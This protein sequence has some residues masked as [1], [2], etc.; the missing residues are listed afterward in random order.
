M[1]RLQHLRDRLSLA[2]VAIASLSVLL[3]GGMAWQSA[4]IA[5]A[6]AAWAFVRRLPEQQSK[7]AARLW[8]FGIFLALIAS[9]ARALL[10]AEFLDAGVD[11]LLLLI[12]QRLFNR[13]RARE[14]L[15][16]LLLGTLLIVIG[17]VIN[18][19]FTY[20]ILFAA[21]VVVAAMTLIVN[22]LASEGE[23]LGARV[24]ADAARSGYRNRR[25]LWRAAGSVSVLAA[26]GALTV[27]FVFP[28]WGV[29]VFLRGAMAR[30]AQ[31]GFSGDV[32]LGG[33]GRIKSDATVVARL[34]PLTEIEKTSRL[35]WHLRGSSLDHYEDGRWSHGRRAPSTE[36]R[37]MGSFYALERRGQ[38]DV[39]GLPSPPG[40]G[41][42]RYGARPVPGFA[43]SAQ[44][45]RVVVT[46]EDLGV[47][48]LFAASEPVAVRLT[49]RGALERRYGVRGGRNGELK[50][51]KPPGPLQ[52]E[53]MSRPERPTVPEMQAVGDPRP[54]KG[55][56]VFRQRSDELSAE[57][58]DLAREITEGAQTRYDKVA[59]VMD[60]LEDYDYT[61]ELLS[62]DRVEA[63]A[64]PI[65]GFLFDTKAGH[66]EYFA[67]AMAVLLREVDVPT[68]IVNGYY[69][70]H[71]NEVGEFYAVRQAD[72]H[73]WVEVHMGPLGW[74]TFDPTPPDG[75][76]AGDDAPLWPAGRELVDAMRNAYLQYV[77]DYNLQKQIAIL[78]N[79]GVRERGPGRAKVDWKAIGGW[80]A[81][82]IALGLIVRQIRRFRTRPRE[83]VEAAQLGRVLKA[84]IARG[85]K[86]RPEESPRRFA[87]RIKAPYA[88]TVR[89]FAV[90]YEDQRFGPSP[91]AA[92]RA[93]LRALADKAIEAI[94]RSTA[95]RDVS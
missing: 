50:V 48:A 36:V 70:A 81:G 40:R 23:R 68:R 58:T 94:R 2:Q 93:R 8:T 83:S 9:G 84:L 16:L 74:V 85:H 59:A 13:Q 30:D 79:L 49:P 71:Y 77:I 53:F 73:S 19:D 24:A 34:V 22:H 14:H 28:R 66:C 60:H 63:G 10:R 5:T 82:L 75:R 46:L 62:S 54:K 26:V 7:R 39:V 76:L 72:A 88:A 1:N 15:Q 47:D 45:L 44:T 91:S 43:A 89:R 55:L 41:A 35:T 29:G 64:D 38:A 12:V 25:T 78:E 42:R 56:A 3:G 61:L 57:V 65:E 69:G 27:F 18:T 32:Q 80:L 20:P 11:F 17:A 6:L 90:A 31:S 51:S 4:A 67:T 37:P 86:P 95:D 33:F 92:G 87:G 52:Y 21:Y